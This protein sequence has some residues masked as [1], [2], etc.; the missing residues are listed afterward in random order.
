MEIRV[1]TDRDAAKYWYLR[2]ESLQKEPFAFGKS[3]EEHEATTIENLAARLRE[4]PPDFTLGAFEDEDLIGMAT[5]IRENGRKDRHK[6]RIYGVYVNVKHRRKKIGRALIEEL[7]K[8]VREDSSLEQ[9]LI[10]V[11]TR[12]EAARQLYRSFGFQPFGIEPRALKIGT[13]YVDEEHMVLP[14]SRK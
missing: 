7:L 8:R 6:G 12:Q 2:L 1:L 13:E 11:T 4:M 3:A 10:S 5:F 14:L 9:I